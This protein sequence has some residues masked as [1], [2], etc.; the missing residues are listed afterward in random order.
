M[1][2]ICLHINTVLIRRTS[3]RRLRAFQ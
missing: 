1:L 2:H 3:G